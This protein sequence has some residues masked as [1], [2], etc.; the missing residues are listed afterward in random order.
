MFSYKATLGLVSSVID[1]KWDEH[2]LCYMMLCHYMRYI[3]GSSDTVLLRGDH[4][5]SRRITL[6]NWPVTEDKRFL[7][8]MVSITAPISILKN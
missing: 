2:L 8:K 6:H 7:T 5:I 1:L 3:T 4:V